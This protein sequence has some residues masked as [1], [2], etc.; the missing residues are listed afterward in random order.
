MVERNHESK[1]LI[2]HPKDTT[3]AVTLTYLQER[4]S[5]VNSAFIQVAKTTIIK[6]NELSFIKSKVKGRTKDFDNGKM[7]IF[8]GCYSDKDIDIADVKLDSIENNSM[9]VPM[10]NRSGSDVRLKKGEI[11]GYLN[12]V[13]A[14]EENGCNM[15]DE[16]FVSTLD[17]KREALMSDEEQGQFNSIFNK[18]RT[19]IDNTPVT[20]PC[21]I[22][23]EHRIDLIDDKP[24]SLPA[25]RIPYNIKNEVKE[26]VQKLIEKNVIEHSS[27][28]YSAPLVPVVKK[29]GSIRLCFDY[30]QLNAKTI[31]SKYPIPRPDEIFDKLRNAQVFSVIDL[32]NGYYHIPIRKEDRHET[33]FI[34]PWCKLQF[35]RMSQ[36]LLGAP[37]TFSEGI[38][39]VIAD[40]EEFC[41]GFFDD[42]IVFSTSVEEHLKHLEKLFDRLAKF[43]LHINYTKCQFVQSEVRF[44]G[45][46]ITSKGLLPSPANTDKIL[47]FARPTNI[48]Q[49]RS[50]LGM[51]SYYKIFIENFS[52]V[53]APLFSLTKKDNQFLWTDQCDTSFQYIKTSLENPN[54]LTQPD[55]SKPFVLQT[56]ASGQGLGFVLSQDKDGKLLPVRFG[57]R[58]LTETEQRYDAT[59]RELLA[60]FYSVKQNEVYLFRSKYVV[61]TDHK[62]LVYLK[63]FKDIIKKRFRW[64]EYLEEMNVNIVYIKGKENIVADFFSRNWN[65]VGEWKVINCCMVDLVEYN[66]S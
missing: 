20:E 34:L 63:A 21:R 61:Y 1:E 50:F 2:L 57:G 56:D 27:S 9:S 18:Y 43:R 15:S 48:D 10:L 55:C 62:P 64:I 3:K 66:N 37:F 24:I 47:R 30:R 5:G 52:I 40:L 36:G 59:N 46:L 60:V 16:L 14:V 25:R 32:K 29:D 65:T 44:L 45:H 17:L 31:P 38:D 6:D 26:E 53:A 19:C 51:A 11:V 42:L 12:S 39:Y 58:V 13:E 54:I 28:A 49:L 4:K 23:I 7:F 8:E 41:D 35:T 33:A 22:P